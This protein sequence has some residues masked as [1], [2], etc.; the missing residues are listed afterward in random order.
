MLSYLHKVVKV[1]LSQGLLYKISTCDKLM[2][3][4]SHTLHFNVTNIDKKNKTDIALYTSYLILAIELFLTL[5]VRLYYFE[6]CIF[7]GLLCVC[8]SQFPRISYVDF[9]TK[10]HSILH[11][12]CLFSCVLLNLFVGV[13]FSFLCVIA[14]VIMYIICSVNF[15]KLLIS[16]SSY[17]DHFV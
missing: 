7:C 16:V 6:Q 11:C 3:T 4:T 5:C 14:Y 10:K 12:V 8:S 1:L 9:D 13:F 15:F 17:A 2:Y